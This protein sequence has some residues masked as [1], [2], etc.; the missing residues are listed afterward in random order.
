MRLR[1]LLR[2][3]LHQGGF[4]LLVPIGVLLMVVADGVAATISAAL[5]VAGASTMLACSALYHRVPHREARRRDQYRRVDHAAIYVAI[6][7][8][9]VPVCVVGLPS[10]W[11]VPLLVVVTAGAAGGVICSL[12]DTGPAR[13]IAGV[14]YIALGWAG[15]VAFPTL[16]IES[17]WLPVLLLLGG[18]LAYTAGAIGFA[19]NRPRL[20]P[21]VFG[22]HEVWH[23]WTLVALACHT[24]A[25]WQLTS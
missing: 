5:F 23:A 3:W 24:L 6:L 1:P 10:T 13:R 15:I 8:T 4:L 21:R 9:Y 19:L 25:V 11:G 16:V 12:I 22:Y 18:G 20:W 7:G 2:G 17:G 14:L